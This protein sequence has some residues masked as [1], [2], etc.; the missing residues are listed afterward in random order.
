MLTGQGDEPG[1]RGV[2]LVKIIDF[3]LAKAV[4]TSGS[5]EKVSETRGGFVG[6]P[7]FASPEQFE[8]A[9]ANEIEGR[10]DIFSLGVTLWY[11]LCGQPPFAGQDLDTIRAQHFAPL[12]L[13]QLTARKVPRCC[14]ELLQSMLAAKRGTS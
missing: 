5:T 14:V 2:P 6:T 12:P 1:R 9:V 4:S 10:S 7:T 13:E 3:G 8:G 11:G